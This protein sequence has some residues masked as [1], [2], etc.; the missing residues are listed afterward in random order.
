MSNRTSTLGALVFVSI[1]LAGGVVAV[2]EALTGTTPADGTSDQF[3]AVE[4]L[5]AGG[6]EL[7]PVVLVLLAAVAVVAVISGRL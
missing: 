6:F 4:E 7:F 5:L 2:N 1:V 3:D